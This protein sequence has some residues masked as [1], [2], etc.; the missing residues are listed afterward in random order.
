MRIVSWRLEIQLGRVRHA[1]EKRRVR[2][3]GRRNLTVVARCE[4]TRDVVERPAAAGDVEHRPHEKSD[5]VM[6][7]SVGFDLEHQP[8][9]PFAPSRLGDATTMIVLGGRR[10]EYGEAPE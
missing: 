4:E 7:E 5:H 3:R 1:I 6:Q 9:G 10:T 2:R 8:T